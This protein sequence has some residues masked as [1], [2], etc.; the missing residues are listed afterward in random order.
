MNVLKFFSWFVIFRHFSG[1]THDKHVRGFFMKAGVPASEMP[2]K[3]DSSGK[4]P[5]V[6]CHHCDVCDLE[7]NSVQT[8]NQHMNGKN[9]LK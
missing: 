9:H 1:K 7:F 3:M 8:L 6:E 5:K 4:F 2:Q